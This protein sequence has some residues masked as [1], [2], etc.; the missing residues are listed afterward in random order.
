MKTNR[1]VLL[2]LVLVLSAGLVLP[3]FAAD[4]VAVES[5]TLNKESA[6]L[7]VGK[8]VSVKAKIAPNNATNRKVAWSSS[9]ENVATVSNGTVTAK[10]VG[11]AVITAEAEDGSGAS[12]Q[13]EVTVMIPVRKI[14][15]SETKQLALAPL[16]T[17][18][19]TAQ[20]EPEDATNQDLI[21]TS[22][23]EKVASVDNNGNVTG[24]APGTARITV[25]AADGFGIKASFNV[26]V[27][28]YDYIFETNEPHDF[29]YHVMPGNHYV[30]AKGKTGCVNVLDPN[31]SIAVIATGYITQSTS[32]SPVKAGPDTISIT[33]SGKN[34]TYKV[35]VSPSVFPESGAAAL[36]EENGEAA[37]ILFLNLPWG[38][39]FPEAKSTLSGQGK[40]V[41]EPAQRND[42]IRAQIKSEIT[43][44]SCTATNAALDFSYEPGTEN[45]KKENSLFKGVLYFDPE[46]PFDQIRL[47]VRSVYGLDNGEMN[48]DVC[49]WKQ[50]D[51][52][53]TLT[54]KD[55]YIILEIGKEA[56]GE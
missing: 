30:H 51:V 49:T 44:G 9:D 37:E 22:S 29:E 16:I 15:L 6:V 54:P 10:G 8:T 31:M 12:A 33:G 11:T 42:F 14:T 19:V 39:S 32:A 38:C 35:F 47:A 3:A 24:V 18:R 17:W 13:M 34:V 7:A 20:V 40:T 27:E 25:E 56:A 53:I 46:T 26:K 5:I 36:P 4:P 2:F 52:T 43:F 50:G 1:F 48:G 41:K 55:R 28:N 21:W 23:S 45:Y